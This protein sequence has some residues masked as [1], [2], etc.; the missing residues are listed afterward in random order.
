[1]ATGKMI[2]VILNGPWHQ[3][4]NLTVPYGKGRFFPSS[5]TS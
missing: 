3:G 5:H 4:A 2:F 1:M